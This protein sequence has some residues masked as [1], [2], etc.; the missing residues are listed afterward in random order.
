MLIDECVRGG[1]NVELYEESVTLAQ[2]QFGAESFPSDG[3]WAA[4]ATA[5]LHE[6][7]AKL[8]ADIKA[9]KI[10]AIKENIRVG[11]NDLGTFLVQRGQ[12]ALAM[13]AFQKNKDR[14]HF[15]LFVF[16]CPN[17]CV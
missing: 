17:P 16:C 15:C 6:T 2:R 13:R 3:E 1:T 7:Q 10:N 11:Q 9:A 12:V 14:V 4:A 8:E 5:R